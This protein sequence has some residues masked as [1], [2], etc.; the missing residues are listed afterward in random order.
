M[1][2]STRKGYSKTMRTRTPTQDDVAL[3]RDMLKSMDVEDD[4][5]NFAEAWGQ[6]HG[7]NAE[8]LSDMYAKSMMKGVY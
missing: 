8:L 1:Q 6:A 3:F 4:H 7:I 5:E 2:S